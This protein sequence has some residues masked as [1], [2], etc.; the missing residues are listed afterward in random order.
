MFVITFII[1]ISY[2]HIGLHYIGR[3]D[4]IGHSVLVL[5]YCVVVIGFIS[6]VLSYCVVYID[7]V[8]TWCID[9]IGIQYGHVSAFGF[10]I[11][12][13]CIDCVFIVVL[14]YA[15]Y[16]MY[17][18]MCIVRFGLFMCCFILGMH[19]FVIGLSLVSSYI[20]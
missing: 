5:S 4:H 9:I 15:V 20:G 19:V 18:D 14:S 16:Y 17:S 7:V 12:V 6:G 8:F 11:Y 3:V 1:I 10:T 2:L 13:L